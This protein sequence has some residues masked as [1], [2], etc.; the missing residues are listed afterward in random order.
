MKSFPGPPSK[1]MVSEVKDTQVTLSWQP[2]SN[3]GDSPVFSYVVEYFSHETA[4]VSIYY[5]TFVYWRLG[6]I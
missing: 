2:N 3:Q 4:D 6:D 1:P 5:V